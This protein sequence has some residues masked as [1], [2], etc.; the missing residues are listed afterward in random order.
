M[1]APPSRAATPSATTRAS[2]PGDGKRPVAADDYLRLSR[3]LPPQ[4]CLKYAT[5]QW[6]VM[7]AAREAPISKEVLLKILTKSAEAS[8]SVID[9]IRVEVNKIQ[10]AKNLSDEKALL[11]F[12]QNFEHALDQLIGAIRN[13]YGVSEKA[14]DASF[15]QHQSDPVHRHRGL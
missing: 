7:K 11:L 2:T 13:Q 14:M 15:K 10:V 9:R 12:Q 1:T 4:V 8:K 6:A 3:Y 5:D